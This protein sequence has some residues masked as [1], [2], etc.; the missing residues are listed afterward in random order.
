MVC[1]HG[2]NVGCGF[3]GDK[4]QTVCIYGDMRKILA[5]VQQDRQNEMQDPIVKSATV[6]AHIVHFIYLEAIYT[7]SSQPIK[8]P[9]MLS[10]I[11][12]PNSALSYSL[13]MSLSQVQQ[14]TPRKCLLV[15]TPTKFVHL[16]PPMN[17]VNQS[18]K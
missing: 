2:D 1:G 3:D 6:E 17:A 12:I 16:L 5:E 7:Y 9:A 11:A 14:R 8:H 15:P 10:A 13:R 18:E 4:C